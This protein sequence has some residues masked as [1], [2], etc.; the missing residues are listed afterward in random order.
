MLNISYIMNLQNKQRFLAIMY[1]K[2]INIS[3]VH[4]CYHSSQ[5]LQK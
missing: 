2:Q 3:L 1:L 4:H 5:I